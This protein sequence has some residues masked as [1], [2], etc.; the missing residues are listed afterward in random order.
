M[1]ET[2][3]FAMDQIHLVF[4]ENKSSM[5]ASIVLSEYGYRNKSSMKASIGFHSSN[6]DI[7]ICG[8]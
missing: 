4:E 3:K 8:R 6:T 7:E 2:K 5:K 1:G